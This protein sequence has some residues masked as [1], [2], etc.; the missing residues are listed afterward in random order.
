MQWIC[1]CPILF[2]LFAIG[3]TAGGATI[4][5]GSG[6][7]LAS[8]LTHTLSV[9]SLDVHRIPVSLNAGTYSVSNFSFHNVTQGV[10]AGAIVPFLARLTNPGVEDI[11]PTRAYQTIWVGPSVAVNSVSDIDD[12]ANVITVSYAGTQ[13]FSLALGEN[14]YAG[15]FTTGTARVAYRP[16][17][18]E[19][20]VGYW[21]RIVWDSTA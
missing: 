7:V 2:S 16:A 15:F 20:F 12:P 18:A 13:Q 4:G 8:P 5:P 10:T 21:L 1:A 17:L 19:E 14:L 6:I 3:S 11:G 9:P